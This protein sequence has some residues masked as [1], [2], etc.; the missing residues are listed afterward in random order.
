MGFLDKLRKKK[1]PTPQ[2]C[3]LIHLDGVNLADHVYQESDLSTLED[4]L[5][6]AINNE[7][8]GELDGNETGPETTTIFTYGTDADRLFAAM[9]CAM[10]RT[11]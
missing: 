1:P 7:N 5:I 4:L 6:E 3:V 8:A 2:E 10:L 11:V 9:R